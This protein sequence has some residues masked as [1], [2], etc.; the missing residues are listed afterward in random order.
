[1]RGVTLIEILIIVAI[2]GI[3]GALLAGIPAQRRAEAEFMAQ[4]EQYEKLYQCQM[5]WR[6]MHPDPIVVYAP[7][8]R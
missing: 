6:Q 4:C 2:V 3:L 8:N 7:L 5:K 1:M